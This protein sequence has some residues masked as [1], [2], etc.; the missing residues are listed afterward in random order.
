MEAASCMSVCDEIAITGPTTG[1]MI[2]KVEEDNES[3]SAGGEGRQRDSFN[4]R[5]CRA[6]QSS[7][8]F[9]AGR[10]CV[11]FRGYLGNV[12]S[13]IH[14]MK[15]TYPT[16]CLHTTDALKAPRVT[17]KINK[18]NRLAVSLARRQD[19]LGAGL[20]RVLFPIVGSVMYGCYRMDGKEFRLSSIVSRATECLEIKPILPTMR[21]GFHSNPMTAPGVVSPSFSSGDWLPTRGK[22][23]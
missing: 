23:G 5:F 13:S 9:T 14:K 6:A 11:V 3:I 10:K 19:I 20:T 16:I 7:I 2:I 4:L 8:S 21:L 18:H 12:I 22:Q 1:A 15:Q 17:G